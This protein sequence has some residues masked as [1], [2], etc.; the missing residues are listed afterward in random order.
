MPT[1]HTCKR[2]FHPMGI[3]RHRAAHKD[4]GESCTITFTH[5]DTYRYNFSKVK[6]EFKRR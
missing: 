1:C 4:K 6:K 2:Y 5:G 3:A